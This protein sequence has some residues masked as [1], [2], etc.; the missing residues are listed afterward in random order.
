MDHK[1]QAENLLLLK[2]FLETENIRY[3]IDCGTLLGAVRDKGFISG[4]TDADISVSRSDIAK[5]RSKIKNLESLG[6]ISFR[7]S[8]SWIAMSLLRK[9]EYIDFYTHWQTIPFEL[10]PYPFLETTFLIPKYYDEYL[11][12]QYGNWRLPDPKKRGSDNWEAGMKEYVKN[13][14][15][16]YT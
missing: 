5:I 14:N 3:Y 10:S 12:E 15:F 7:N 2:K 13:H 11:T 9:G 1:I 16:L 8:N 4:D 6:F